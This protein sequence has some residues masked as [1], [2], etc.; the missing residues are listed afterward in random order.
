VHDYFKI[1]LEIVWRV[2]NLHLPELKTAAAE[3][4]AGLSG[5]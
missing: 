4:L 5:P 1:D 2:I 3:M